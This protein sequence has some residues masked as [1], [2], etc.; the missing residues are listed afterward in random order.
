M[1]IKYTHTNIISKDWKK[2]ADFYVGVFDCKPVGNETHLIG[3][4]V[5]KGSGVAGADI[6]GIHLLMPGFDKDGPTLEIFQYSQNLGK[7]FP[8]VANRE[9]FGHI[10]FQVDDV[11]SVLEKV[12]ASG[13]NKVGEVAV[14]EFK[15]GVLTFVY[16]SDPEGNI[17][18]LTKWEKK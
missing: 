12:I 7:Q 5:E 17:L 14:K 16:V 15:S 2:L 13:G 4:W 9:G 6:V 8:E 3:N 11:N 10:A 18:E 1:S